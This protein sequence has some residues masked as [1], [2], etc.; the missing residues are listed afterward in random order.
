MNDPEAKRE[1]MPIKTINCAG[2]DGLYFFL[3]YCSCGI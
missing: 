3:D 2:R 1:L